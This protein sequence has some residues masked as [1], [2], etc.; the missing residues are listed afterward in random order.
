V[1]GDRLP[2]PLECREKPT[3]AERLEQI[4]IPPDVTLGSSGVLNGLSESDFIAR[5]RIDGRGRLGSPMPW[6][7]FARMTDDD[8]GAIYRYLKTLPSGD[9]GRS[10]AGSAPTP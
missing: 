2:G 9:A 5:F 10:A 8:L 4:V 3:G 1:R 7:A 6:E